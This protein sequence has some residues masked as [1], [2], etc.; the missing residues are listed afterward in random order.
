MIDI[1]REFKGREVISPSIREQ[2]RISEQVAEQPVSETEIGVR[3][4][5][6]QVESAT[7]ITPVITSPKLAVPPLQSKIENILQEDLA[8]L[9]RELS[10]ADQQK[11]KVKGEQTASQISALI[12]VVKVKVQ[13]IIKLLID[14]LKILPGINK[15]FIE[16]E[17][18]I[19]AD[20]ILKLKQ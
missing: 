11:F 7:P 17:A 20:K 13:E 5:P 12:Q 8:E 1:K 15:Y 10:P 16:Q 4:T 2:E 14:W 6:V 19:K 9:Y 3:H 18:K